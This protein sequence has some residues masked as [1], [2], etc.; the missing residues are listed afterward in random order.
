MRCRRRSLSSDCDRSHPLS[1]SALHVPSWRRYP[2]GAEPAPEGGVHFRVWA[3]RR[4]AVVDPSAFRWTDDGWKGVTDATPVLY[5]MH[6]GTFT[7]AGTWAAAI[8]ELPQLAALGVSILE[9]MPVAEFPGNFGWGYDG[10]DLFAPTRL[11][12]TPDNMRA[13]VDRAH[14][15]GLGVI[16]DV[17]YNH[18]GPDGNYLTEFSAEY[19]TDR[20]ANEWGDAIN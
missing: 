20:Y 1:P 15:L 12:G 19:F 3:P 18:L 17:V 9:I 2:V 14:A 16:L 13:F 5:E 10:V 6:V 11:Y 7:R 4:A 8:T